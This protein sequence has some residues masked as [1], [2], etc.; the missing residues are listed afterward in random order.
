[1]GSLLYS[2]MVLYDTYM[3]VFIYFQFFPSVYLMGLMSEKEELK[4]SL[5]INGV[6]SVMMAGILVHLLFFVSNWVWAVLE[7]RSELVLDQA[8]SLFCL[9]MF[10]ALEMNLTYL[11]VRTQELVDITVIMLRMSWSGV[12]DFMVSD[13]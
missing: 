3:Y 13:I 7:Q 5:T 6:L 4:Y 1:M 11:H 12:Q 10:I 8:T 2:T 9:M